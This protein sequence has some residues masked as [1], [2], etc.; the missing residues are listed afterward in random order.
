MPNTETI[1]SFYNSYLGKLEKPTERHKFIFQTLDG[2]ILKNAAVLDIGCGTGITSKHLAERAKSVVAIDLSPVL[3]DFALFNNSNINLQYFVADIIDWESKTKFDFIFMI[4]VFEH[5]PVESIPAL[6][7][8]LKDL[9]HEKTQIYL[10]IP[11]FDVLNYLSQHHPDAMQIV[12]E[13]H[14][15]VTIY[16]REIGFYPMYSRLY[17]G[18]YIEYLFYPEQMMKNTFKGI[19]KS[20]EKKAS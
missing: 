10:N 18:Q 8:K 16:F 11:S 15:D 5:I 17:W 3:I 7:G 13:P 2:L 14:K 6:M 20:L 4:D 12:D 9:S 1:R 19:F